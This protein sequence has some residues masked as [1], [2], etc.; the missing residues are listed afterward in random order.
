MLR[1]SLGVKKRYG[2]DIELP[3]FYKLKP[4]TV[5]KENVTIEKTDIPEVKVEKKPET[6]GRTVVYTCITGGYEKLVAPVKTP[7]F[8]YICFTDN[9]SLEPNGWEIRP[10]PEGLEGLTKVKQ[11][12]MVKVLPHKYLPD[13]DISIWV[14]GSIKIKK[15]LRE[16]L[17][18]FIYSGYSIFIPTHPTRSCIYK[19]CEVVKKIKKDTTDLPDK[20]MK[21]YK[22]EGFPEKYGLVQSNIMV[23]W[24]NDEDCKKVMEVWAAE[25]REFSHRDQLSFNYALWKTKAKCFKAL[26]KK[27]CNSDYFYWDNTHGKPIKTVK[28]K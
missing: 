17:K 3:A 8:D 2:A 18:T 23:R 21:K 4:E 24:H 13:Y 6:S 27:T 26:D 1:K 25:I 20:Q 11:Q 5:A 16:F 22:A 28:K 10:M 12:R 14:D 7:G 19:E 15:D 9:P